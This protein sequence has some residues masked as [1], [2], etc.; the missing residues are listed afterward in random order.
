M[1]IILVYLSLFISSIAFSQ[2]QPDYK[3]PSLPIEKRVEDLLQ[4]MTLAEKVAQMNHLYNGDYIV[5]GQIDYAKLKSLTNNLSYGCIEGFVFSAAQYADVISDLQ[6]HMVENTRLGIP[7]IPVTEGLHGLVQD[8]CTIFPQALA[9]GSTF[10]PVL[11]NKMASFIGESAEAIGIKQVL[12]PDLDIARE[13]RWGRVEETY[14]EDPYLNGIMGILYIN[15]I[16]QFDVAC[17]PKHFAAHNSPMGGLNLASASLGMRQLW[18]IDLVPFEMVFKNTDPL[19]AM[20]AYSSWDGE[21]I[22]GSKYFLTEILRNKFGFKG[23]VYSDWGSID[24]LRYFHGV[25][26]DK[27][28]AAK[29]AIEAGIDLE[30]PSADAYTLANIE[31]LINSNLLDINLIDNS[32]RRILTVKFRLGLFDKPINDISKVKALIHNEASVE[33]AREIANESIILLKNE[34]V[35]PIDISKF[36]SIAMIGPNADQVQFGDYTWSKS[37]M[38]GISPLTAL[39][40]FAGNKVQVNYARGCD[41]W[42]KNADGIQEAVEV[43]KKSD[44]TIIVVGTTS[45]S[46]S[47]DYS[48]ATSGEGFDL[49]DLVLPGVQEELIK[50][51]YANGKP[52]IVV[53]VSG[54]PLAIPWVKQNIPAIVVQW[55]GGE[56]QGNA[57]I[58]VIFGKVNPSGKLN[59]SFPQSVGHLPCYYNYLPTDKGFYHE[60]GT[61]EKPGRDYVFSN[62]DALWNFG[63]GLSYTNFE[64]S[65]FSVSNE[66]PGINDTI[67]IALKIKNT[68]EYDGKEVIQ[69]YVR[70]VVSSVV[71]PVKQL[72]DFKKQFV[73][74]GSTVPV[75]LRLPVSALYL[76]NKDMQKVVEP[77]DFEIQVGNASDNIIFTKTIRVGFELPATGNT[78]KKDQETKIVK[79]PGKPITVRGIVR[80]VQSA[81][82]ANVEVSVKGG[83]SKIKTDSNGKYMLKVKTGD[84]LIFSLK[85]YVSKEVLV[86]D[87]GNINVLMSK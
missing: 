27:S 57:L 28:E 59:V 38:D 9:L 55:Y 70:D 62:P 3:N 73:K 52:V 63:Y 13:L 83:K 26:K 46:L 69:L 32:V 14:G 66:T 8:G 12:S 74:A 22:A 72:K 49:S 6:K 76:Y 79:L 18:S 87:S 53:L 65:D 5:K 48:N 78:Q 64:L 2:T 19:S 39:K 86:D 67:D 71:T 11:I 68:G 29:F 41:L 54:K 21:P 7:V 24:M 44:I 56:Q 4:R 23:Y 35:L 33:L 60:A 50:K 61:P 34:N 51:V 58:D 45:A 25:A 17:T 84:I 77:G 81:Q 82:M 30:A 16:R 15:G 80:D 85:G 43:S 75:S 31:N 1:K 37:N 10:N 36:K 42:S 47:R 40:S 20:N